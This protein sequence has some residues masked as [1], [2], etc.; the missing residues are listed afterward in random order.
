MM[1]FV[2]PRILAQYFY[3][4]QK[5]VRETDVHFAGKACA[6]LGTTDHW[7]YTVLYSG[8]LRAFTLHF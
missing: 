1:Q 3:R 4:W 7:E 6:E 8:S 2:I 5:S